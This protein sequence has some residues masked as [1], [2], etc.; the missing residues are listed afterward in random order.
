MK[1]RECREKE[2]KDKYKLSSRKNVEGIESSSKCQPALN[3]RKGNSDST[4]AKDRIHIVSVCVCVC[5]KMDMHICV[6]N[7]ICIKYPS[8]CLHM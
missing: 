1:S 7:C 6:C 5:I 4:L 2:G 3:M 8:M